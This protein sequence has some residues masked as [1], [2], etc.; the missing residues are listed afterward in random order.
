MT[1]IC[2]PWTYYFIKYSLSARRKIQK[3]LTGVN[4]ETLWIIQII[5]FFIDLQRP[6]TSYHDIINLIYV[7][8]AVFSFDTTMQQVD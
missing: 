8:M 1:L 3:K 4:R 6:S 7:R 2:L 5:E